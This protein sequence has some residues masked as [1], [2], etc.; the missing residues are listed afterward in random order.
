MNWFSNPATTSTLLLSA[1]RRWIFRL[2]NDLRF[3]HRSDRFDS[4]LKA[5]IWKC[6]KIIFLLEFRSIYCVL[7]GDP[8]PNFLAWTILYRASWQILPP[9][10]AGCF[11]MSNFKYS[12]FK[13]PTRIYIYTCI[14][15][16]KIMRQWYSLNVLIIAILLITVCVCVCVC[17][18][19]FVC[20]KLSVRA[21]DDTRSVLTGLNLKFSFP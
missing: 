10:R 2:G 16:K 18:C 15:C 5:V 14:K 3:L 8:V 17:V 13:I 9:Y 7:F 19:V 11:Y 6:I 4:K 1:I 12:Y 21:R 20:V